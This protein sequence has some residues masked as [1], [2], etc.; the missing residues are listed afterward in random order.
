MAIDLPATL[1]ALGDRLRLIIGLRVWDYPPDK[2]APPAAIVGFPSEISYDA[3]VMRGLDRVVIP[4]SVLVGKVSDRASR[5]VLAAYLSGTGASS[6]KT[7]IEGDGGTL[8]GVADTVRVSSARVEFVTVNS[9]DYLAGE[10][11]VEVHS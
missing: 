9:I 5:T 10:F 4:V 8:G 11:D 1:E 6:V 3:T 2:I 7:I